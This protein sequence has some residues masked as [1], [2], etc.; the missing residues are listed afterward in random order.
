[1]HD[2]THHAT[3]TAVT[4]AVTGPIF[5]LFLFFWPEILQSFGGRLLTQR[6]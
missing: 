5:L 6:Y 4:R 2:T 1:M 3:Q